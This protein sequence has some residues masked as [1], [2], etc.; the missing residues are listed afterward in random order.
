[1]TDRPAAGTRSPEQTGRRNLQ[2][3]LASILINTAIILLLPALSRPLELPLMFTVELVEPRQQ[4][5]RKPPPEIPVLTPTEDSLTEQAAGA[6]SDSASLQSLR[7]AE[8]SSSAP[9]QASSPS[10]LEARQDPRDAGKSPQPGQASQSSS[11]TQTPQTDAD[12]PNQSTV[13]DTS[14]PVKSE[15]S[16]EKTTPSG[17]GSPSSADVPASQKTADPVTNKPA[18]NVDSEAPAQPD[19]KANQPATDPK[20]EQHSPDVKVSEKPSETTDKPAVTTSTENSPEVNV[21]AD[22]PDSDTT[23]APETGPPAAPPGPSEAELSILGDY[24]DAARRKIRRL[25]RTPERARERDIKGP[26][27]FE[28][29]IDRE[30]KLISVRAIESAH[31]ILEQ[32]CFEATRVAAPFGK[33]PKGVTVKSWKFRMKLEFPIV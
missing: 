20:P 15:Q 28:F 24:G 12:N 7:Q 32:E 4:Q 18:V 9:T 21:S 13:V 30:G 26:V 2:F 19:D 23:G 1:M 17:E 11:H 25:V 3:L 27:T 14:R 31:K 5:E 16:P 33:F 6:Q 29:E 8:T 22:K 10:N